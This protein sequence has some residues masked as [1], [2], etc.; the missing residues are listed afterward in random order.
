M[1]G[2]QEGHNSVEMRAYQLWE[3]RGRPWGSPETDWFAA[4]RE[5]VRERSQVPPTVAAAK[6]VGSV[7]G[8]VAGVVSTIVDT[9]QSELHS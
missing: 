2:E 7:L 6:F 1:Q 9:V 4:E 8:S 3:Q 5:S